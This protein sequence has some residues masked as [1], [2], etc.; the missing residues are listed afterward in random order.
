MDRH[1]LFHKRFGKVVERLGLGLAHE[2]HAVVVKVELCV[3]VG[4]MSVF[5]CFFYEVGTDAELPYGLA[6][7]EGFRVGPYDALVVV[8]TFI[9]YVPLAYFLL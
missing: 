9:H 4:T 3:G 5:E 2:F 1:T 7:L 8:E 6:Q